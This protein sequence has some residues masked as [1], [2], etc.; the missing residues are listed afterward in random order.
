RT[1]LRVEPGR[2]DAARGPVAGKD[3]GRAACRPALVWGA[4]PVGKRFARELLRQG[5]PLAGFVDLDPRKIGQRIFDV[6]VVGQPD[7]G[8][9]RGALALAAV[10]SPGAREEIRAA[11]DVAGWQ[12]GV[13][14]VAVA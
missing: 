14:Y 8:R 10:G 3:G 12:E 4:G 5:V 6:L 1:L 7:V 9:F 2:G 13:D 11:L